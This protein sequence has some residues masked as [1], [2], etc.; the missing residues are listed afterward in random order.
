MLGGDLHDVRAV[1][2]QR[3]RAGWPR[4]DTS[5]IQHTDSGQRPVSVRQRLRRTVADLDDLH[6]R[7]RGD[8][9]GLRMQRPLVHGAHHSTSA[10]GGDDG[11]LELQCVPLGDRSANRIPIFLYAE[12]S[13]GGGTVIREVAVQVAPTSVFGGIEPH[14]AVAI[15]RNRC[16]IQRQVPRT[17]Q[18]GSCLPRVDGN[19]LAAPRAHLPQVGD[20]QAHRRQCSRAGLAD[21]ERRGQY[22]ISVVGDIN[23]SRALRIPARDRQDGAQELVGHGGHTPFADQDWDVPLAE[24]A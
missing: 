2:R 11:L 13:E 20:G 6:Q 17:A 15:G 24:S 22:R 9:C 16:G 18:R 7:Q 5:Q 3:T 21:A 10:P 12:H 1:L 8:G 4:Q 19:L 14:D 23:V